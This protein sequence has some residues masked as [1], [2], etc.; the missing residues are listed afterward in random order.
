MKKNLFA[1]LL[2]LATTL[3]VACEKES[4]TPIEEITPTTGLFIL[5]EG[6]WHQSNS[7]LAFYNLETKKD[8]KDL[9]SLVNGRTL[10]DTANDMIKV[11]NRLFIVVNE[12]STL[13]VVDI[14]TGKSIRQIKLTDE[15]GKPRM[16]RQIVQDGKYVYITAFDHTVTRLNISDFSSQSIKVGLNAEGIEVVNGKLYVACSGDWNAGYDNKLYVV[17]IASFSVERTIE[18]GLNPSMIA[19]DKDGDVYVLCMGNFYDVTGSFYRIDTKTNTA[20]KID[21]IVGS[22]VEIKDHTAYIIQGAYP[23]PGKVVVFD[24]KSDKVLRDL[25]TDGTEVDSPYALS[26][27]QFNGNVYVT[28]STYLEPGDLYCFS[29]EGKLQ[30]KVEE[31]GIGPN[32]IVTK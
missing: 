16:P 21:G 29:A 2:L 23:T 30:Y 9:F 5:N 32:T 24:C 31:V 15:N 1:C 8:E 20:T 26:I 4:S 10:G 19:K 7:T 14:E 11:D 13:E 3:F 12:S 18:V 22:E 25:V 28:T 27:D 6:L 17:D